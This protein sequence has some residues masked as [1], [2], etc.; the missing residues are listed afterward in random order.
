MTSTPPKLDYSESATKTEPTQRLNQCAGTLD[1]LDVAGAAPIDSGVSEL[2]EAL[3][4]FVDDLAQDRTD[5]A[6]AC[7]QTA[8][9]LGQ[10]WDELAEKDKAWADAFADL[11]PAATAPAQ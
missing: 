8:E 1:G 3:Q 2:D 6:D 7:R 5:V 10:A 11:T 9:L 4:A